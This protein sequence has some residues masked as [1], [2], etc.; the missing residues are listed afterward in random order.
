MIYKAITN[1]SIMNDVT[2]ITLDNIPNQLKIIADIFTAIANED[3]NIDMISQ[4]AP[5][6]GSL[7]ISFTLP[8]DDLI[9]A[10]NVLGK[11]K[12]EIPGMRADINSNN[13][14]LSVYGDAMRDIPGV[15]AK[16]FAL[17][18]E[19]EIPI[20][21]ITTSEVDISCLIYEKDVDKA[22][23]CVKETFGI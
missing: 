13:C 6:R 14:K 2:L 8:T 23:T 12:K 19:N 1:I 11:F 3:I 9:K 10:I 7:N 5:Y 16:F 18:E 22:R 4:T 15:A 20:K 17:L 21:L